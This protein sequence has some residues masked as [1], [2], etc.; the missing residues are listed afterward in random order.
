MSGT[1]MTLIE[2]IFTDFL[3]VGICKISLI[4]VLLIN[5]TK[6][7]SILYLILVRGYKNL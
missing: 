6:V 4:S 3:P 2:Q 7:C 5:P 1:L